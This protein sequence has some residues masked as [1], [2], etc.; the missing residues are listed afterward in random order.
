M[1]FKVK[2]SSEDDLLYIQ[3]A[4]TGISEVKGQQEH[5]KGTKGHQ[6]IY[7]CIFLYDAYAPCL[8]H[9]FL[10]RLKLVLIYYFLSISMYL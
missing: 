8:N 6:M 1:R 7:Y 3:V 5:V 2:T 10:V 4:I 9:Y